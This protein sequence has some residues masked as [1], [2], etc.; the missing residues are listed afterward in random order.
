MTHRIFRILPAIVIVLFALPFVA[1]AQTDFNV[2]EASN[3]AILYAGSA[4]KTLNF[5]NS[6]ITGNI[7]IGGTG[8]FGSAG[9]CSG[10]C[11]I[12][13]VVEFSNSNTGQFSTNG[14]TYVPALSTGVNPLYS[15]S[16]VTSALSTVNSLSTT[17]GAETGTAISI[18]GGLSINASTGNL[19]NGDEVFTA[20]ISSSF[21]AGSTFTING[22]NSQYVV[23]NIPTTGGHG[24]NGQV[25]LTG[26]ITSDHVLF[27]LDGTDSLQMSGNCSSQTCA[28]SG[29][30]LDP[31]GAISVNHDVIDGRIIGG[32]SSNLQFVSGAYIIAPP[33]PTPEPASMLLYGTGLLLV[34]GILRRRMT[35]SFPAIS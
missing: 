32:D 28:T 34:G 19:V 17:L 7:G 4:G 15:Q 14:T 25:V 24:L 10:P 35:Q 30:F 13:G 6:G 22:T 2:G 12:T 23:I 16:S 26:G 21:T 29:I 8:A 31:N 33:S 3:F 18:G 9:G 5:S 20:T 27:N 11:L 1:R